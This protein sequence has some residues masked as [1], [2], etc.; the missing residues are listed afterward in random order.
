M[1]Q[2]YRI[3]GD[4]LQE[5]AATVLER[6]GV[7]ADQAADAAQ[8]LV[9]A[10]RRGVDTHGVRNLKS[11][12]ADKVT[13]GSIKA[14]PELRIDYETPISA[15]V[16]GDNGLGMVAGCWGM[17]LAI[18]KARQS[19][20]GMVAMHNSNHFGAAG[21]YPAMAL[22]EDL[23]G[24]G[25][26]GFLWAEGKDAGVVPTFGAR[27]MFS[28][29]PISIGFPADQEP[30]FLLDMATSTTPMN[31]IVM[32]Q[33]LGEPIPL[34]WALDADGNPTT[35]PAAARMLL[36]LGGTR[37][38]GSHK[39]YGL[40]V[41]VETVCALLSGGWSALTEPLANGLD[42]AQSRDAHFFAAM[43][44]DLFRPLDEFKRGMDAMIRTLRSTP[45]Q[46][47]QDRVYVAGEIEQITEQKRRR[48]GI[49]LPPNVIAD[50]WEL[51]RQYDVPLLVEK[52]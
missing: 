20:I 27:A 13:N 30:P 38:H 5:F 3:R 4:R 52:R 9:W 40:A 19:G 37:E 35:D 25:L 39:G 1:S 28:T 47:D 46:P 26:T 16:D 24:V 41:M 31:R 44:V 23:I 2:E 34:G 33:E 22:A 6:A 7:P 12:Y 51:S 18:Q 42:H 17:R 8:V 11:H 45:T 36:P 32:R 10:N 29:N 14:R 15:R 50:L 48:E 43:R 21:H 49:P